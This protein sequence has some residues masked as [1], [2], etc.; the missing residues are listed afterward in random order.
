MHKLL[1]SIPITGD[2]VSLWVPSGQ[3]RAMD[4]IRGNHGQCYGTHPNVPVLPNLINP[5]LGWS[6]DGTDDYVN[7]GNPTSLNVKEE[8][9]V[10][11]WVNWQALAAWKVSIGRMTPGWLTG[12]YG[13]FW[14][15]NNL[16]FWVN[17]YT[18][19]DAS[20][21]FTDTAKWC[22][23]VGTYN[24]NAGSN[25]VNIYLNGILGTPGTCT[26]D[27]VNTNNFHIG[28]GQTGTNFVN[29]YIALPFIA[30][31]AWSAQQVNN[32]YLATRSFFSPRG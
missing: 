18:D 1:R 22:F 5:S 20:I 12:G 8:F 14:N 4:I 21:S 13:I 11:A 17:H 30:K 26:E 27:I 25:E 7:C 9:T 6:F 28:C 3:N 23:I 16:Y 24:K 15:S 32:F 29:G 10:G 19:H 2:M 31:S